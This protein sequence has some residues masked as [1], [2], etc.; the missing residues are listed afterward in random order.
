MG[1]VEINGSGVTPGSV[2][3][4]VGFAIVV[5]LF[6]V[7]FTTVVSLVLHHCFVLSHRFD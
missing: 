2:T 4:T 6:C 3:V 1:Y 7:A 5:C